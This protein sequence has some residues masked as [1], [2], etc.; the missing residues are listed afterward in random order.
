[1]GDGVGVWFW[2]W[3]LEGWWYEMMSGSRYVAKVFSVPV[4]NAV[5]VGCV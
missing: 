2:F 3:G 1:M 5:L 4:Q